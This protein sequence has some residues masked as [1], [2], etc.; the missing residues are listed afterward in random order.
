M[1][2][3]NGYD[4][5]RSAELFRSLDA[6]ATLLA[7]AL[8]DDREPLLSR[9]NQ[10]AGVRCP[11]VIGRLIAMLGIGAYPKAHHFLPSLHAHQLA[12]WFEGH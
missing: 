10:L 9:A 3:I 12:L 7:N 4:Y 6:R 11:S 8:C 1:I 5:A 2:T